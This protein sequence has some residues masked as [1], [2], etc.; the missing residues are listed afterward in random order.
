MGISP[1][2]AAPEQVDR[3]IGPRDYRTD[4]YQLGVTAY[5]LLAGELPFD[6]E[7]PESLEQ[8]ILAGDPSHPSSVVPA[9]PESVEEIVLTAMATDR[10]ERYEAAIQLRD[11][12]KDAYHSIRES[13]ETP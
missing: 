4:I 3:T 12:R 8:R 11:A 2:Y 13:D 1:P 6:P 9:L 5:E 10:N 7:A